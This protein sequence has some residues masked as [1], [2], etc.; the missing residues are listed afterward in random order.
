MQRKLNEHFKVVRK[1]NVQRE[2]Y[3]QRA[4]LQRR[5]VLGEPIVYTLAAEAVPCVRHTTWVLFNLL[6]AFTPL[7]RELGFVGLATSVY[8][9]DGAQF[10]SLYRRARQRH[11][12]FHAAILDVQKRERS[13]RMDNFL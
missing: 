1:P 5:S 7:L 4:M 8:I 6:D 3:C 12:T 2:F 13:K 9:F 11:S 10:H